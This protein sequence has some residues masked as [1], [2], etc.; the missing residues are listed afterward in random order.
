MKVEEAE[1]IVEV[2]IN[3]LDAEWVGQPGLVARHGFALAEAKAE[4]AEA[5]AQ[6]E[7]IEAQT[8]NEV[9]SH[10]D[11]Y[12]IEKVTE[13]VIE[14]HVKTAQAV[15][16]ARQR[17]QA[18]SLTVD[19]LG[20]VMNALEHRKRSLEN[21]VELHGREYFSAPRQPD[22]QAAKENLTKAKDRNQPYK[23]NSR[24]RHD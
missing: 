9:R 2:D 5:K 21:L 6:L 8:D 18:A 10:P 17:L 1:S 14:T 23:I 24:K 7:L 13:K 3:R 4:Q 19:Q 15:I 20:V 16:T 11:A 12:G 22:S